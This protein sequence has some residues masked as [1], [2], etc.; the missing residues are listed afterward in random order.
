MEEVHAVVNNAFHSAG[1]STW[2]VFLSLLWF[3][4]CINYH[5]RNPGALI[6]I[7]LS[8][9][10]SQIKKKIKIKIWCLTAAAVLLVRRRKAIQSSGIHIPTWSFFFYFLSLSLS[11]FFLSGYPS[12][13]S[14]FLSASNQRCCM[15]L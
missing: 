13:L 15:T 3:L 10:P 11:L 6:L 14:P 7:F 12:P 1:A 4:D 5:A 9:F 2:V 8:F